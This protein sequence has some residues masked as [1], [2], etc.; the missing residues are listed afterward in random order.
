MNH[1][2][3]CLRTTIAYWRVKF[4]FSHVVCNAKINNKPPQNAIVDIKN[5][6]APNCIKKNNKYVAILFLCLF[7]VNNR[8]AVSCN[9]SPIW[10]GKQIIVMCAYP[11]G[12][13]AYIA[14]M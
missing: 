8:I 1:F 2:I 11:K 6:D 13:V 10:Y 9:N 7:D 4:L 5:K 14:V 12:K 3:S